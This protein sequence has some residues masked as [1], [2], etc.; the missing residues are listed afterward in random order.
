[1]AKKTKTFR[2][3]NVDIFSWI[4]KQDSSINDDIFKVDE[5]QFVIR[6]LNQFNGE[7]HVARYLRGNQ[8]IKY[9]YLGYSSHDHLSW[10]YGTLHLPEMT[11]KGCNIEAYKCL[12]F[13][14]KMR[15]FIDN[16]EKIDAKYG[17]EIAEKV[18]EWINEGFIYVFEC[19]N[20]KI[21]LKPKDQNIMEFIH[22]KYAP[23]RVSEKSFAANNF[24]NIIGQDMIGTNI[25]TIDPN[26]GTAPV[27]VQVVE[28]KI[29]KTARAIKNFFSSKNT[30]KDSKDITSVENVGT[31]ISK[32]ENTHENEGK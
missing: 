31:N 25:K 11:E 16:Q 8:P 4:R 15:E 28:S 26:A 20:G 13:R 3:N 29:K 7:I 5:R 23:T 17:D 12:Y 30:D 14:P 9:G 1:M 19:E 27:V 2:T 10:E 24:I 32:E 6:V 21:N 18:K 22:G